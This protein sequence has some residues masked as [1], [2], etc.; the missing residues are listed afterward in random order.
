MVETQNMATAMT[1]EL[2]GDT[3]ALEDLS[4]V[5]DGELDLQ[6]QAEQDPHHRAQWSTYGLIGDAMR[7]PGLIKPVSAAF[8]VRLSAALAREPAHNVNRPLGQTPALKPRSSPGWFAWPSLAIAAAV[9][10]VIWVAQPLLSTED[11]AS[12]ALALTESA[13]L[14]PA[15]V[16]DYMD[17]HRQ[18]SGPIAVR[19][20]SHLPGAER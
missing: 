4:A 3:E 11:A 6:S 12:P 15:I 8:S 20:A 19:Q 18:L 1:N 5:F 9:A 13:E 16:H 17:A 10:S 7:D 14:D 2:G